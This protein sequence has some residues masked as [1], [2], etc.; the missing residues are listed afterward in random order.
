MNRFVTGTEEN[1]KLL[2][3]CLLKP[4]IPPHIY[5]RYKSSEMKDGELGCPTVV[6]FKH[7]FLSIS[8]T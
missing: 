5:V 4:N 1:S 7:R 6:I 8:H 2:V 3:M